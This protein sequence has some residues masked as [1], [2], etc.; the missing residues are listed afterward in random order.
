MNQ[1]QIDQVEKLRESG[2][3][4]GKIAVRLGLSVNTVKA[5]CIRHGISNDPSK[6]KEKEAVGRCPQCG[7]RLVQTRG[8]RQKRFCSKKCRTAWWQAHPEQINRTVLSTVVCEHCG[9]SFV[10]YGNRPRKY[11]SRACYIAHVLRRT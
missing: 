8:H 4:Y 10:K 2:M 6:A 1:Q 3:S 5:H 9:K 11:C 7:A